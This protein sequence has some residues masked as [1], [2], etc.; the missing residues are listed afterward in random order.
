MGI[1]LIDAGVKTTASRRP[2]TR[3]EIRQA[4]RQVSE[5]VW[6]KNHIEAGRPEAG[7]CAARQIEAK[8]SQ[9]ELCTCERCDIYNEGMLTALRWVL[10]HEWDL[11]DS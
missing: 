10:G 2:R 1:H 7:E 6:Y 3:A 11:L 5:K 4:M 9:E 8:Y